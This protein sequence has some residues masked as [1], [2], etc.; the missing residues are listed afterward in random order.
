MDSITPPICKPVREDLARPAP[1]APSVGAPLDVDPAAL[2]HHA[3]D[4]EFVESHAADWDDWGHWRVAVGQ[5]R[6]CIRHVGPEKVATVLELLLESIREEGH[7][8]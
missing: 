3:E 6:V 7:A 8:K 5:I 4:Q 1:L 2:A